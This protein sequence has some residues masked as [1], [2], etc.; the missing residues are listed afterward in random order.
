M[1]PPPTGWIEATGLPPGVRG[2]TATRRFAGVSVDP[3]GP[4]NYSDRGGDD[5]TA[6]ARNRALLREHLGLPAEPLWLQQ[7]H[8][9]DVL[10]EPSLLGLAPSPVEPSLLGLAHS[11]ASS[12]LRSVRGEDSTAGAAV[13]VEP[14]LLGFPTAP[15]VE[16]SLL[17]SAHS[18]ASSALRSVRGEDSTVSAAFPVEPN[19]LGL[20]HSGAS[21]ALRS[22]RGE[23]ST[24]SA[25]LPVEPSLLGFPTAPPVEPSLLGSG[26][27]G[28]SSALRAA[29]CADACVVRGNGVAAVVLTAD[30]LPLLLA[31]GDRV[32]AVH[33]GWRGLADGVIEAAVRALGAPPGEVHAWLGPAIGQRA[34][35]VG[36][37]VRATFVGADPAAAACFVPGRDDRWHADLYAL[38]RLRLRKLGVQC[39]SGGSWCTFDDPAQFHSYR[40]DGARSGRMATLIWRV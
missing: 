21:S 30:C 1:S 16:P 34:F 24:A 39:I 15:P 14:S 17:G 31:A 9:T 22:V 6:V 3:F 10:V 29:R 23:D 27:S 2:G 12:A 4:A 36:P 28:A 33:A 25:A 7:V 5:P 40:R 35:E 19:L 8:G 26:P 18:G 38:A 20:A 37:E 11:G 13:P 32:A